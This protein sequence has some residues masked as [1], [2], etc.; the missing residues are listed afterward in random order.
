[1]S[2]T[3]NEIGNNY[4]YLTVIERVE[5][6]KDNRAQW[7]CKCICGNEIVAAGK[8]LRN[9]HVKSCGC[10][11]KEKIIMRNMEK[12][13][14]DLTGQKFG[15]LTVI[16]F[17]H[18]KDSKNGHRDRIWKCKCECGNYCLVNHRY[19]RCGDTNSCGC[20]KSLGEQKIAQWLQNN[21]YNFQTEYSFKDLVSKQ[22]SP[23]RFDFAI[24]ENEEL[25]FLIEYQGNIHFEVG[26]GWNTKEQLKDCQ[27]RDEIKMNF[28]KN[29]KIMLYYITY[30]ENIENRL[31][32]IFNEQFNKCN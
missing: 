18:W 4:N 5:N 11:N 22:N 25:K 31:K 19:L 26:S 21:N 24:F 20:I 10:L 7:K 29:K 6:S 16:N 1:M 28:C 27:L 32:E 13:G 3:I 14:G 15:K 17:D 8:L 9:G 12:G 2:K 23:Y 30:K